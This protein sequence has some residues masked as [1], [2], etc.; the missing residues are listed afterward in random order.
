[1]TDN[2]A[3]TTND[4]GTVETDGG[5]TTE[6]NPT[7]YLDAEVNIFR[8]ETAFMRDHLKL[9][10]ATFLAWT[11]AVFGPVTAALVAPDLMTETIVLGFQLHV[12]LTGIGAPFGALVLSA[13]YAY[14]RDKLD[15]KYG[16]EH[17]QSTGTATDSTAATDGGENA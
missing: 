10:W 17:G 16:I 1:M 8:P 6:Q 12:L 2:R 9:I 7:N 5:V 14:R 4:S 3:R 15:E 11:V 13:V